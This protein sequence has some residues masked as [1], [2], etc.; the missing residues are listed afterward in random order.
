M[1]P[2]VCFSISVRVW[3]CNGRY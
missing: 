1:L 3:C 2:S